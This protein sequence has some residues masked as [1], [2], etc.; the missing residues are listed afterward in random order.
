MQVLYSKT[1]FTSEMKALINS[2]HLKQNK[3]KICLYVLSLPTQ[4][5][6]ELHLGEDESEVLEVL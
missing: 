4:N 2:R 1:T 5:I 6:S 3:K